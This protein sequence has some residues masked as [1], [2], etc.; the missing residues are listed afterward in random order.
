MSIKDIL[1]PK[2]KEEIFAILDQESDR[3]LRR[4]FIKTIAKKDDMI[5]N[6]LTQYCSERRPLFGEIMNELNVIF[7]CFRNI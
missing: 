3:K 5:F 4:R 7:N 2:S 6:I 1:R